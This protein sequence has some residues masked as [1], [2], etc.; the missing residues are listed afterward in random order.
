MCLA[1]RPN[2]YVHS[3]STAERYPSAF[4]SPVQ[5]Q[6]RRP[7]GY[8][9][10]LPGVAGFLQI[11]DVFTA[12]LTLSPPAI[13]LTESYTDLL[14]VASKTFG[15]PREEARPFLAEGVFA[16]VLLDM[17]SYYQQTKMV[18]HSD[19]SSLVVNRFVRYRDSIQYRLL[20]LLK[21]KF[22]VCRLAAMIYSYGVLFSLPDPR[23]MKQLAKQL[24]LVLTESEVSA[25]EDNKLRL[26]AAFMCGM[27]TVQ[28]DTYNE[29][30]II[31]AS[32]TRKLALL[33]WSDIVLALQE[34]LWLPSA[35]NEGGYRLWLQI[36][37]MEE[38]HD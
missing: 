38:H 23:P 7:L 37:H 3:I 14:E 6:K 31:I 29:F 15:P 16:D 5:I 21:G 35:R 22:D 36:S 12:S 20:Q 27:A 11:S 18:A 34:F 9:F 33:D 4:E 30:A 10:H 2:S 26:W 28:D 8:N 1:A 19:S 25:A 17:R 13:L 24:H 32:C